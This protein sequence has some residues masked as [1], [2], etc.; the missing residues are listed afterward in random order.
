MNKKRTSFLS[1][2]IPSMCVIFSVLCLVILAL[3]TL[4]TS[5]QDLQ[6]SRLSLDQTTAYYTACSTATQQYSQISD[7]ITS[8]L[9]DSS[10]KKDY[11]SRMSSIQEKFPDLANLTWT[12]DT[13]V[14]S[15]TVA[16]TDTQ[17]VYIEIS[18]PYP[19]GSSGSGK[20]FTPEILTWKTITTASW[21]PDTRQ[22][23]FTGNDT[24][25]SKNKEQERKQKKSQT[26]QKRKQQT[27]Q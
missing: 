3:L 5:R 10:E 8:A 21:T 1:I 19:S 12:K 25:N 15:F 4:G 6:T 23:V 18:A 9:T 11:L 7:F 27:S 2:G 13:Q 17:A 22:P 14:L 24:K 16:F 26:K 20:D